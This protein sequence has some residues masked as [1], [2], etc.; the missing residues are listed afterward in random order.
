MADEYGYSFSSVG[1]DFVRAIVG[2][3]LCSL[4]VLLGLEFIL[5]L[6][7]LVPLTAVFITFLVRIIIR[8]LPTVPVTDEWIRVNS[9]FDITLY[10]ADVTDFKLSYFTLWRNGEKGWMEM[11]LRNATNSVKIESSLVGFEAIA[12]RAFAAAEANHIS[13]NSTTTSNLEAFGFNSKRRGGG[14]G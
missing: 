12:S 9:F 4:P 13:L 2:L 7:L 6:W 5:A 1:G 3:V 14:V 10:W 8:S 11:R